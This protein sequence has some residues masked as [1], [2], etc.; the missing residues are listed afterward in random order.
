MERNV[1]GKENIFLDHKSTDNVQRF[2]ETWT[3]EISHI[4]QS[5]YIIQLKP[6]MFGAV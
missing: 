3:Q 1:Y 5:I 4:S 6:N 2:M